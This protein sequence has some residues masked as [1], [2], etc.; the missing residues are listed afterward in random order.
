MSKT[1]TITVPPD[2]TV[3][4][5]PTG[6]IERAIGGT[7]TLNI[8]NQSGAAITLGEA[9]SATK[10]TVDSVPGSIADAAD[11]D[12]VLTVVSTPAVLDFNG[13][14]QVTVQTPKEIAVYD[15]ATPIA[16]GG[17][18]D[19]GSVAK[20]EALSKT[21][22]IENTGDQTLTLTDA[23]F[24]GAD[25]AKFSVAGDS[26]WDGTTD[27][28]VAGGTDTSFKIEVDTSAAGTFSTTLTI[29][30]DDPDEGTYEIGLSVTVASDAVGRHSALG[31]SPWVHQTPRQRIMP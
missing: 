9:G 11:D 4:L 20:D 2:T 6:S 21:L 15:G 19:L 31:H 29:A 10:F 1:I 7:V 5:P 23:A 27:T 24:S 13:S 14:T 25:A 26:T 30:S 16:D 8:D 18:L 28:P 22:T 3:N 12:F 17:S